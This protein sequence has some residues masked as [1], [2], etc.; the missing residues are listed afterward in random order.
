VKIPEDS[1]KILFTC[2]VDQE[3]CDSRSKDRQLLISVFLKNNVVTLK[4]TFYL[5]QDLC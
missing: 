3:A 2:R 1:L 4:E 5:L